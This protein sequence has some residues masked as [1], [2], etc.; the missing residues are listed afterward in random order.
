M[1]VNT[2][3]SRVLSTEDKRRKKFIDQEIKRASE[4]LELLKKLKNI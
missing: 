1:P 2:I 4:Y 3:K